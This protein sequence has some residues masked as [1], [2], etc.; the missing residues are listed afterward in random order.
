MPAMRV[1]V[2]G[3]SGFLG[4]YVVRA[5]AESGAV[6]SGGGLAAPAVAG[7]EHALALDVTDPHSVAR[8]F[9][10]ARPEVVVHLAGFSSVGRS[11]EQEALCW[12]INADG[13]AR[14]LEAAEKSGARVL[15]ASTAEVYGAAGADGR[16]LAETVASQ[17]ISPYGRSKVAAEGLVLAAGGVVAR[18]F[19]VVGPGQA[20][21]FAIP[22]WAA[23]LARRTPLLTVGKLDNRRDFLHAA[24]A[25]AALRL[26][27]ESGGSQ[28]YNVATGE[29]TT[30][31][32]MLK[33]LCELAG[34][35]PEIVVAEE[36]LRPAD[37][38]ALRGDAGRLRALGWQPRRDYR[39]ALRQIWDEAARAAEVER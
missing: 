21:D 17:P 13:T 26:L 2:T 22:R 5:L 30:L 10:V 11:W 35:T 32:D 31:A 8:A 39:I 24:D 4:P 23:A 25:A 7:L 33:I 14:V 34:Y 1:L 20:S 3:A 18:L 19:S 37:P 36:N 16:L 27:A 15:L 38:P 9:D 6:V 12:R 29:T 28:P